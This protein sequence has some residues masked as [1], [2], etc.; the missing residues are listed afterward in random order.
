MTDL[1]KQVYEPID[2]NGGVN[3]VQQV[4]KTVRG[5]NRRKRTYLF[6][7]SLSQDIEL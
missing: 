5:H 6:T 4:R 1:C 2:A 7:N 3:H